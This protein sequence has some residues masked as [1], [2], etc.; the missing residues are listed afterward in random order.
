M[1]FATPTDT[2]LTRYRFGNFIGEE[3]EA[4][5]DGSQNGADAGNYVYD[6]EYAEE[7]QEAGQELMEI[8]GKSRHT[9]PDAIFADFPANHI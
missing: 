4:S 5:E 8:D 3:A 1:S 9:Q 2:D 7:E 6:D